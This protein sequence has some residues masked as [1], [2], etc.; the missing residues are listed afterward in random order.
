MSFKK[1][2]S[3]CFPPFLLLCDIILDVYSI[4]FYSTIRLF[5]YIL[6]WAKMTNG[7]FLENICREMSRKVFVEKVQF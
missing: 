2:G 7:E 5:N 4:I 6:E 3:D 1:L